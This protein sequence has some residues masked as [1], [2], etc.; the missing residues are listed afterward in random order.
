MS[1]ENTLGTETHAFDQWREKTTDREG[2]L[3]DLIVDA[4]GNLAN[5]VEYVSGTSTVATMNR[6]G[7]VG[8]SRS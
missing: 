5:V 7:F 8:G 3:K 2:H 1:I 4:Y 6:P